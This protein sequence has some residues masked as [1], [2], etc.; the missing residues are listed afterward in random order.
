MPTNLWDVIRTIW[1]ATPFAFVGL[2]MLILL[3]VIG[4]HQQN[5]SLNGIKT[6]TVGNGQHG[7]ARW[8]TQKEIDRTYTRVPFEPE[9]WRRGE[10]RPEKL[11]G[12]IL[13]CEYRRIIKCWA[14]VKHKRWKATALVDTDDIHALMTAA[15][16]AGKTAYFLY[17][18]IEYALASGMSFLCTDTK[19][20]LFRNYAGIAKEYY[21]YNA[22]VLDLRNPT[23]SDG[24]NLLHLINK[25]MDVYKSDPTNLAAKAKSEKYAKILAETII[26]TG[27]QD[28]NYGQNQFFYDAAE[29]LLTSVF[30][31]VAEFLPTE[32]ADGNPIE[33]RHIVSVFKL[34]QELVGPSKTKGKSQFQE[35]MEKLPPNHKAKWFAG[36]ALNSAEQA[37]ASVLSTVLS[38]LNAFLDSE[39]EQILCFETAIDAEKFCKERSAIFIVL[40]EEDT[41]KY[42]MV[43]LII[44]NLYR[45]ILTVADENGGR[46]KNRVVFF[47][48]EL[49]TCPPIKSLELMFSASRSRG[50]MMVPIIQSI[51]G[52]LQKNYGKEGSEII[53]DNCQVSIFGGF[54]PGSQTAQELSRSLGS[55]TVL[56]GSVSK[57]KDTSQ[58]LQ[59]MERPLMTPDEL[60]TMPKGSFVVTKTGVHPMKTRLRLFLDWGIRFG[61]P[62]EVPEKAQR[63][64]AYAEKK[65]LE[66]AILRRRNRTIKTE[67]KS[68]EA[69][70]G[71]MA[72]AAMEQALV[73]AEALEISPEKREQPDA[74]VR[75]K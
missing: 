13:G 18:N 26:N 4:N 3:V 54:A 67:E 62:Y 34:V 53:V 23:R 59:M 71:G 56:S 68:G 17:P 25:Y 72:D 35:L 33:Q 16:G 63:P 39:M 47:A 37:M 24:N 14:D 45:E 19:G 40:P 46:L 61:K 6:K 11:Q 5:Y 32:D 10:D 36:S 1:T 65:E 20:D 2:A 49:G 50:V 70:A 29:G 66:N 15:S 57:G 8:A 31:L 9:K 38:R 73:L 60:K 51:T 30:L 64:V 75:S 55:Q 52:Q 44:Q 7:T 21:G 41:T 42:F 12:L 43:S 74:F 48:D 28:T 27:G 58:T 69:K 22:S